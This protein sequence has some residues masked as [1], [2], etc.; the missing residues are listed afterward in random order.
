MIDVGNKRI[1]TNKIWKSQPDV[2]TNSHSFEITEYFDSTNNSYDITSVPNAAFYNIDEEMGQYFHLVFELETEWLKNSKYNALLQSAYEIVDFTSAEDSYDIFDST[3][4]IDSTNFTY[5][6]TT[7]LDTTTLS[8][9]IHVS[10]LGDFTIYNNITNIENFDITDTEMLIFKVEVA[11]NT[12]LNNF[13]NEDL[14][15]NINFYDNIAL[16]FN[17]GDQSKNVNIDVLS[18]SCEINDIYID[19]NEKIL[20]FGNFTKKFPLWYSY[21]LRKFETTDTT[22]FQLYNVGEM[23]SENFFTPNTQYIASTG[24]WNDV[25]NSIE[26]SGSFSDNVNLDDHNSHTIFSTYNLEWWDSGQDGEEHRLFERNYG[27]SCGFFVDATDSTIIYNGVNVDNFQGA[28][29][30][31]DHI[32][33]WGYKLNDVH[34][35]A[36]KTVF[37]NTSYVISKDTDFTHSFEKLWFDGTAIDATI[38][39]NERKYYNN[40]SIPFYDNEGDVEWGQVN[41]YNNMKNFLWFNFELNDTEM[42]YF[43][44]NIDSIYDIILAEKNKCGTITTTGTNT[45]V[46]FSSQNYSKFGQLYDVNRSFEIIAFKYD[47][48]LYIFVNGKL[49]DIHENI[50]G[51]ISIDKIKMYSNK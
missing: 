49:V 40:I 35:M 22:N 34:Q 43:N 30:V 46:G 41:T 42:S 29:P 47:L 8:D 15:N 44:D 12:S 38:E 11:D 33:V 7:N 48:K 18:K 9:S 28:T 3:T 32:N 2:T 37:Y 17:I 25:T 24:I 10:S 20:N 16:T 21:K 51:Q 6:D 19:T 26:M 27:Y 31:A 39:I 45:F 14:F 50:L 5:E 36:D 13:H 1:K 4:P 23:K